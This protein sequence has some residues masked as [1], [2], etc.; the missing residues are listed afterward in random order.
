MDGKEGGGGYLVV[1]MLNDLNYR[2]DRLSL[3]SCIVRRIYT[4]V[5]QRKD[6]NYDRK[7][8]HAPLA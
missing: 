6:L 3:Y 8:K 4:S 7:R 5:V 2:I 1:R